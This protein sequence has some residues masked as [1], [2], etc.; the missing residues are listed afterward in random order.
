MT[1]YFTG[2]NEDVIAEIKI[3]RLRRNKRWQGYLIK[4]HEPKYQLGR[5]S[6]PAALRKDV[7]PSIE[8]RA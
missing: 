7:R 2:E 1:R 6:Q 4:K 3:A 5:T 8:E